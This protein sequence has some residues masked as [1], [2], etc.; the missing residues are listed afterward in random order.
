[1][2]QS[3]RTGLANCGIISLYRQGYAKRLRYIHKAGIDLTTRPLY[4]KNI[5]SLHNHPSTRHA[6]DPIFLSKYIAKELRYRAIIGSFYYNPFNVDCT[7]SLL[8]C[9]PRE[10]QSSHGSSMTLV[11]PGHSVNDGIPPDKYLSEPYKLRLPGVDRLVYF[12]NRKVVACLVFKK[13]LRRAYR[14]VPV[15]PHNYHLLEMTVDGS[16]LYFH[17]AMP[18]G[19]RS[20]TIACQRTT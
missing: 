19:L 13:D 10:I 18:F 2:M 16:L 15:D 9:A 6:Q 20:A 7:I 11:P 12:I 5:I 17:T 3:S 8:Q 4:L 14:Q 1:M